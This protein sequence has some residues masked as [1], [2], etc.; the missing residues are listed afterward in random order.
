MIGALRFYQREL[1]DGLVPR[2]DDEYYLKDITT[3]GGTCAALDAPEIDDLIEE[4]LQL[5]RRE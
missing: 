5:L 4:K 3:D 2:S 1:T